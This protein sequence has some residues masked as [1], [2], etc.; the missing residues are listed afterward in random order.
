MADL[1]P[2]I[3]STIWCI[4]PFLNALTDKA[5]YQVNLEKYHVVG[6]LFMVLCGCLVSLSSLFLTTGIPIVDSL[7]ETF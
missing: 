4:Q 5:L 1:N 7:I 6:M 3:A 2:G